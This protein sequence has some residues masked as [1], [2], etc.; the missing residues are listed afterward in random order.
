M[1]KRL[2]EVLQ[3]H[4][5]NYILPFLWQHGEEELVIREEIARVH[6]SGIGAICV[7]ARPHPDFLGP[8]WWQDMDIIMDESRMRGMKVW[9]L[10]DDHFPT[11]HAAGKVKEAPE[12]LQRKFLGEHYIDTLGPAKGASLLL[13]T[14][15][16]TGLRPTFS[17]RSNASGTN[18]LISVVA[19]RR[20]PSN[21]ALVGDCVDITEFEHDGT[22]YW[23]I[24]EGYWRIFIISENKDGGSKQQEDYLNPLVRDSVRI[25]LDTVYEPVYERYKADFGKTFAGFFSDEPGFYNDKTTFDFNSKPGKQG[26]SLPWSSEMP[27]L[28]EQALGE[29]Y[30]RQLHLLWH[31][32][33]GQSHIV[34]YT[35]MN[36]VSKLYAENFCNQIG[37]WCRGR[38]VEYI[39]HVL[40]D[41]NVHARLGPGTGHFFRSLW[42]QDMS[43]LDVVLWQI[44][45]GF[46]QLSFR[47]PMGGETDSEFF[48]Y[49]LAKLGVSLGHID[50]KKQGRTMC[51]VYGAYGWTEGLKLMKWLT[52]HMLVRGVN[53]FVP[54]AFTQKAF[55]EPDCP[56][57]MYAGGQNPQYRYYGYLN[58]YINR[59]SHLIS[60]GT[61]V[62]SAAVVYHAE[63]EWSGNA[64]YFH[65]P[66]KALMQHQID[67][68]VI[69]VDVLLEA[70]SVKDHKLVVNREDYSCLII[71]YAEA[72]PA[73]MLERLLQF[74]EQGLPVCFVD[75]FPERSSEG[76]D[77]SGELSSLSAHP[78]VKTCE[79]GKLA[80]GLIAD[81]YYEVRA[82][83]YEPYLR[84]YHYTHDDLDVFMFFN[85]SP[86]QVISTKIVLPVRGDV[87][88]YNAFLNQ[89]RRLE[90]VG[91][92]GART[93]ELVLHPYE[94]IVLLHG[95]SLKDYPAA[96]LQRAT[97][98]TFELKE[99]WTVSIADADH[100]P[101]FKE[102]ETLTVLKNMSGRGDLPSFSGTFRYETE[103]EW[104]NSCNSA[105]LALGEV[106]ETA[107]VW[108]NGEH[109]GM[110][111]CPPYR[112]EIAGQIRQGTNS[113]VIEVTNTLVKD[114]RDFLSS[115]SQQEPSGLI[116]PV[117]ITPVT[118][119]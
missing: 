105:L 79:L 58:R 3:G 51:E 83:Q 16:M 94:S 23:D 119:S 38:G 111:L 82:Q 33:G 53:H 85:E 15:L 86:N 8:K 49:G 35:Y 48:H 68:E 95:P 65:K 101:Q 115:F 10:D 46:D 6:E 97:G 21:G 91:L 75:G 13:D 55:P 66:V 4:E 116:G 32:T 81:G 108:I 40:E 84:N 107:E 60:G 100:Y 71:P 56:P 29:D 39:G 69:P 77:V 31:D 14:L 102:W 61:H 113:L 110:N 93:V 106:Y 36:I 109:V 52:D 98:S 90:V 20:D 47:Q 88:A 78:N 118:G 112:L 96:P 117:T 12:E 34:R 104:N 74:A 17:L 76:I 62:A 63:A 1:S 70:A 37:D 44:V 43:G 114:Q 11:G 27:A 41:N 50:P 64:M 59:I 54:H 80:Q 2:T 22:L 19:V 89:I 92:S 57:H 18:K 26:V 72:L 103:F 28:L 73:A 5:D 42:G 25:L 9:L 7:E 99:E 30:R 67:C 87:Y 24:P 45:P